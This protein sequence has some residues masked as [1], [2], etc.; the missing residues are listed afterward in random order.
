MIHEPVANYFVKNT[1]G[2]GLDERVDASCNFADGDG[3]VV[4][5]IVLEVFLGNL[6]MFS[7][8]T[9]NG[10]VCRCVFAG[11]TLVGDINTFLN[12]IDNELLSVLPTL[13]VNVVVTA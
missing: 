4:S 8:R 1:F 6:E 2:I 5:G 7:A 3:C 13:R 12:V 11:K 9:G 10:F